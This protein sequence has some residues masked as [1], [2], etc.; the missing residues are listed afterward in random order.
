MAQRAKL[1][2]IYISP[3]MYIIADLWVLECKILINDGMNKDKD[4]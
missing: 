2:G 4:L 1:T 3:N